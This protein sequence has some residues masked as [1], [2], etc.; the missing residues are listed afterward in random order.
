MRQWFTRNR[1][2]LAVL[3]VFIVA[4]LLRWQTQS[5]LSGDDHWSLWNAAT[6]L[7][8]DRLFHEFVDIGDPLYW[9][10]SALAQVVFGYRALSEVLLG[11]LLIAAAMAMTFHLSQEASGSA[12]I[13]ATVTALAVLLMTGTKLYSYPKI[14]VYPLGL[15]LAWRYIDRPTLIRLFLLAAGVAVAFG[16]RHD[17]GAYVGVGAVVAVICTH[18]TGGVRAAAF[19]VGRLAGAVLVWLLPYFALV[20]A[21]EGVVAYFQERIRFAAALDTEAR[22]TIPFVVDRSAPASWITIPPAQPVAVGVQWAPDVTPGEQSALERRYGLERPAHAAGDGGRFQYVVEDP[23]PENLGALAADARVGSV[24]GVDGS[25]RRGYDAVD[26]TP[27]GAAIAVQWD[28]AL[29]DEARAAKEQRYHLENPRPDTRDASGR[30]LYDVRDASIEN[31]TALADDYDLRDVQGVRFVKIAKAARLIRQPP[32]GPDV[33]VTWKPDVS[34]E[35]RE[36]LAAQY[37]FAGG[38]VDPE[39]PA[40][41]VYQLVDRSAANATRLYTSPR[42]AKVDGLADGE[43]PDTYVA[44][45]WTPEPAEISVSWTPDVTPEV[46]TALEQQYR[47]RPDT[48]VGPTLQPYTLVDTRR[49]NIEALLTDRRLRDSAGLDRDRHTP[50]ADSWWTSLGREWPFLRVSVAPGYVHK[51]NA[52]VWLHYVSLALPLLVL[53]VLGIDW[54]RRRPSGAAMSSETQKMLVV[55]VLMAVANMALLKRLGSFADHADVA[56]VAGAWLIGRAHAPHS[57]LKTSLA[58][59]VLAL[60]CVAAASHMNLTEMLTR[61]RLQYGWSAV[62]NENVGKFKA[63]ATT[64]PID[65]YAPLNATGDRAFIRYLYECTR[66]D[67]RIWVTTDIY[68][69][70]YYTERR[71]VGHIF[72]GMG[73]LKSPDYERRMIDLVERDQVPMIVGVGGSRPLQH[74]EPYPL[75]HRY[76]SKRYVEHHAILQDKLNGLI[77]WLLTDSR[78][79][80]AGTYQA[81]DLPC[82]A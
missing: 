48:Q 81:L 62:W 15:W 74:L 64:P 3:L 67:D 77:I 24:E 27:D 30:T 23:S 11:S 43:A 57:I 52:A 2:S 13:A 25:F 28:A 34:V 82:Y 5:G 10:V 33:W 54:L 79:T 8:G 32:M 42:V 31:I 69:I 75:V 71:V 16:Y 65:N 68:T 14:F 51:E 44:R 73:F 1:R 78:R 35:E 12:W 76:V 41:V 49:E 60:V 4:F 7:K 53:V 22:R 17:H 18:W 55:A 39:D 58:V 29:A 40:V 66:P 20:Q 38:Y 26:R 50:E 9:A 46:R 80:S 63:L 61:T 59:T 19:G 56:A 37:G 47:L 6:L 21:N 45:E 72:W 70:P 36:R